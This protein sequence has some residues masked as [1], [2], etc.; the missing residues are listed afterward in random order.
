MKTLTAPVKLEHEQATGHRLD[1]HA[2]SI[3]GAII[4]DSELEV[5]AN[6][7]LQADYPTP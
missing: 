2:K 6:R 1:V 5:V 7:A 3:Q 4:P